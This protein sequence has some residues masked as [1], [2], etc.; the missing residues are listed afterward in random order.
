[1]TASYDPDLD[2]ATTVA[3]ALAAHTAD[4]EAEVP[5][6]DGLDAE[7]RE[8]LIELGRAAIIAFTA[9]MDG[10]G[11]RLVPPGLALT[12]QSDAEAAAMM[13]AVRQYTDAQRRKPKLVGSVAPG[14]V[15]PGRLNGK[16]H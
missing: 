13:T 3:K 10:K 14:L 9:W 1:M 6:W 8:S 16:A 7:T 15:V 11:F 5:D 4:D 12:P 2:S